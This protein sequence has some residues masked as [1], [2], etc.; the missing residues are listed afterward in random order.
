MVEHPAASAPALEEIAYQGRLK[1]YLDPAKPAGEGMLWEWRRLQDVVGMRDEPTS[2]RRRVVAWAQLGS[3]F[4]IAEGQWCYMGTQE[5]QAQDPS[6]RIREHCVGSRALLLVL[7]TWLYRMQTPA[8]SRP[9]VWATME[10]I[11]KGAA[12]QAGVCSVFVSVR[13]HVFT[14]GRLGS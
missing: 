4:G 12:E 11:V 2:L 10:S 14:Q 9:L 7:F 1:A 5:Q 13:F 8:R 3:T 6:S